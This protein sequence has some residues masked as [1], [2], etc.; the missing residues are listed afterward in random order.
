MHISRYIQCSCGD[1]RLESSSQYVCHS[2]MSCLIATFWACLS[3][4]L[5]FLTDWRRNRGSTATIPAAVAGLAEW[6]SSQHTPINFPSRRHS[7][8]A[9]FNNTPTF[10]ASDDTDT[11][12]AGMTSPLF[13]QEREL[14]LFSDS[15]HRQAAVSGSSNPQQPTSPYVMHER[16][17]G[18]L[19]H[20]VHD[21]VM[22]EGSCGKLQ[23][24]AHFVRSCGKLQR[25]DCSDVEQSLLNG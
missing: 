1:S 5:L 3:V 14:N 7:F 15:V 8:H 21:H 24:C 16:S 6:L 4:V 12:D 20:C 13:T 19:Q 22:H 17:C 18:K 23:R 2:S 25:S 10:A 11:L 9:D